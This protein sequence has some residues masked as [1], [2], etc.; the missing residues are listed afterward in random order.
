MFDNNIELVFLCLG[1]NFQFDTKVV[2]EEKT[3]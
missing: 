3:V 2:V 1:V